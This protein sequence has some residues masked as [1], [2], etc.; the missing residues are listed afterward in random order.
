M[1][2]V[3]VLS[4]VIP[5][6]E[7]LSNT[8]DL[9]THSLVALEMPEGWAGTSITF[10]SKARAQEDVDGPA[11]APEDLDNVFDSGGNEITWTVAAGRVVVPTAA[12]ESAMRPI[13]YLRIRSG[14]SGTPVNQNPQRIIRL[15]TKEA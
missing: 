4:A 3:K 14:T 13:R 12:H 2:D 10:Q 7:A 8:V 9:G 15:L 6:N 1:A 11:Y 5:P